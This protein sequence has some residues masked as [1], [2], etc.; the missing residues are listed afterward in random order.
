MFRN[1]RFRIPPQYREYLVLIERSLVPISIVQM[2]R[3]ILFPSLLDIILL[4][5]FIGAYALLY[6]D[7]V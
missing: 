1:R 7:L 2:A 3:T 4:T 6:L 5:I